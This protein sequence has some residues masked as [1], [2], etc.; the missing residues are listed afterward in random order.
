MIQKLNPETLAACF[1]DL[2]NLLKDCVDAG[3]NVNFILPFAAADAKLYW[4]EN[5]YPALMR[6]DRSFWVAKL[7]GKIAGTVQLIQKLTP[8]QP[9]R[10]EVTKLLVHP[11]FRR[12]GIADDLMSALITEARSQHKTLI[13]LDTVTDSPAQR[14]YENHGFT[15]A[16]IIPDFALEPNGKTLVPTSYM[17]LKL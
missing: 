2:A 13:T 16:G 7:D 12:R 4:Q 14:L 15:L 6:E 5:A 17:Y 10:A 9:H 1:D 3:A 11:D 8:N